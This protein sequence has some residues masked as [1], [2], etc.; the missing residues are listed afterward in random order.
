MNKT[1]LTLPSSEHLITFL[2]VTECRNITHAADQL[3]RTQSAISV[4]IKKLEEFLGAR[5]FERQS[6]GMSL[7]EDGLKLIPVAKRAVGELRQAGELFRRKLAGRI[8][9]GIPDDYAE[10]VL[11]KVVTEFAGRHPAVE[12]FARSGCTSK[13]PEAVRRKELDMAVHSGADI[14][15]AE[16]IAEERNVWAASDAFVIDDGAPVPLALLIRECG[17]RR[18]PTDA[19]DMAKKD[20]K[21]AYASE[22]FTSIKSAI[23]AGL[24]IGALPACL[25]ET[26]MR[27]LG[28][29]EGFPSLPVSRRGLIVGD[30]APPE[31]AEAMSDAI[32][33][34]IAGAALGERHRH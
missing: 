13:F 23:R 30:H 15:D 6:R 8:R 12:I 31:L 16:V 19:L 33:S 25:V 28:K 7:T 26:G 10:T 18:I 14:A 32:R 2:T 20:W 5:L 3:G 34:A 27:T 4:Q 21:I 11:E 17:W 1:E 24:A 9:I 29:R 22:N